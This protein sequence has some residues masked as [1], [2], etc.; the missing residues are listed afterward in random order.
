MNSKVITLSIL[1]LSHFCFAQKQYSPYM[2]YVE[3]TIVHFED[4]NKTFTN[5][6]Y[7]HFTAPYAESNLQYQEYLD[8]LKNNQLDSLF[9]KAQPNKNIWESID[10]SEKDKKY[11]MNN[12][13]TSKEFQHYPILGLSFEQIHYYLK[14]KTELLTSAYS[15]RKNKTIE[16]IKKNTA[17]YRVPTLM[18]A[19]SNYQVK[20][21][22]NRKEKWL[23]ELQYY[24]IAY[25]PKKVKASKKS[26][27]R[28][29]EKVGVLSVIRTDFKSMSHKNKHIY[30]E[31]VSTLPK[32]YVHPKKG[33]IAVVN[34]IEADKRKLKYPDENII[35]RQADMQQSIRI[36]KEKGLIPSV[37]R[38]EGNIPFVI[39]RV[40]M[41]KIKNLR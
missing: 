13:W 27:H 32:K 9:L 31:L 12:Y 34:K 25:Q 21:N 37:E 5:T 1:L 23:K 4:N 3:K 8:F 36:S 35:I 16:E 20:Q 17:S 22:N 29:L 7:K 33:S 38:L 18:E 26:I 15:L 40:S 11:L 14:W 30:K 10:L 41:A 6:V 19:I 28:R 39:F 2:Q 24:N